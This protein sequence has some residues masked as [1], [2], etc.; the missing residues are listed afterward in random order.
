MHYRW[1]GKG[2]GIIPLQRDA[3]VAAWQY[4][5]TPGEEIWQEPS[6]NK[7]E[8]QLLIVDLCA[9]NTRICRNGYFDL[10][11]LIR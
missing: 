1:Y 10:S 11:I 4:P 8:L 2:T 7:D 9:P 3:A 5:V 6:Y